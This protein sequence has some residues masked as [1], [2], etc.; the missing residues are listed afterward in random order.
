MRKLAEAK[1]AHHAG[2]AADAKTVAAKAGDR[3][4]DTKAAPKP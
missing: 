4:V 1:P 2:K 3:T